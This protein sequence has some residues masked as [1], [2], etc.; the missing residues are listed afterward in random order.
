MTAENQALLDEMWDMEN[1]QQTDNTQTTENAIHEIIVINK[2]YPNPVTTEFTVEYTLK[3]KS[4]VQ[5]VLVSSKGNV[6][7][8]IQKNTQDT[9]FHQETMTCSGLMG[10]TYHLKLIAGQQTINQTIIKN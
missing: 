7:R 3:E 9:G 5:I 8:K 10:G 4:Q 6:V 1:N 2:I